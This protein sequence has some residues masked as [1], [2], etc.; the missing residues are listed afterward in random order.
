[1]SKKRCKNA[2][3]NYVIALGDE[4]LRDWDERRIDYNLAQA[5]LGNTWIRLLKGI[6]WK[7]K[8]FLETCEEMGKILDE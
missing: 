1:M 6:G 3:A 2:E 4:V 5:A 7:R 8:H